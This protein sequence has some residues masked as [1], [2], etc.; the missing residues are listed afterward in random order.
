MKCKTRNFARRRYR[1]DD[2]AAN[3]VR[4]AYG[5]T[6][7][8]WQTDGKESRTQHERRRAR[9]NSR[10]TH[11]KIGGADERHGGNERRERQRNVEYTAEKSAYMRV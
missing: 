11:P 5:R 4:S 10:T 8:E 1:R 2:F 6:Q 9:R 3:F 7:T